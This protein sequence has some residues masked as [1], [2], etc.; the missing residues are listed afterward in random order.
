MECTYNI[1][2]QESLYGLEVSVLRN[3]DLYKSLVV[4]CFRSYRCF[5]SSGRSDF[6]IFSLKNYD[7]INYAKF[8]WS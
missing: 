2:R 8:P 7:L 5:I 4:I 1:R 3:V 6:T